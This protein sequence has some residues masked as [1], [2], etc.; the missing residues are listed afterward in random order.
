MST[1]EY[2]GFTVIPDVLSHSQIEQLR[3]DL[4]EVGGNV[5]ALRGLLDLDFIADLARSKPIRALVEPVLG[6]KCF[7]VRG[8]FFDKTAKANW[9]VPFHQDLTIAVE[10]KIPLAGFGPW[11][12]KDGVPHVQPPVEILRSM[13]SVR[14]HLD[15]CDESN[16][17]LRVVPGS[18]RSGKLE[19][20][21]FIGLIEWSG[22]FPV[23][24]PQGGVMLFRPLLLHASSPAKKPSHRRVVHLEFAVGDLPGGLKWRWNV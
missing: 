17:A 3:A 14:L 18:H 6:P 8:L 7:A 23:P 1:L 2:Q 4:A 9:K 5:H 22:E 19:A 10:E 13:V 15:D 20:D 24:V 21:T 16:G 11:S 12:V